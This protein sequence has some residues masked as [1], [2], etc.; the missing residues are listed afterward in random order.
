MMTTDVARRVERDRSGKP[1]ALRA[2]G[3]AA[4]LLSLVVAFSAC[5][6]GTGQTSGTPTT[7]PPTTKPT[8]TR[9]PTTTTA[10]PATT[11][12]TEPTVQG[13]APG[14]ETLV[15]L[16]TAGGF[17]GTGQGTLIITTAGEVIRKAADGTEEY[18]NLST[19]E[20]NSLVVL[21]ADAPWGTTP[22]VPS[23]PSPCADVFIY[24]VTFQDFVMSYDD[25]TINDLPDGMK[26]VFNQLIERLLTFL[27]TPS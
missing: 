1:A 5:A 22:S 20:L 19:Q 10:V 27:P 4:L 24:T 7:R 21:L 6:P 13:P 18:Q 11:T 12:T 9:P 23:T 16:E 3:L 14:F 2:L 25:C 26:Q 15:K 17:I 8:T